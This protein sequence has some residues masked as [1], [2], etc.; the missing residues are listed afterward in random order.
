MIVL[1]LPFKV[2]VNLPLLPVA[3]AFVELSFSTTV[4]PCKTPSASL[5]VPV[6]ILFW[7]YNAAGSKSNII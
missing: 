7:A 5:T 6:T 1:D 4:A 3:T 2:K